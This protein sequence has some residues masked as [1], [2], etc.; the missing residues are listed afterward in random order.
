MFMAFDTVLEKQLEEQELTL[1]VDLNSRYIRI[2]TESENNSPLYEPEEVVEELAN[3]R[4]PLTL[5]VWLQTADRYFDFSKYRGF[6]S[7]FTS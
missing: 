1:L 6:F 3:I 2:N 7:L 5:D 4:L